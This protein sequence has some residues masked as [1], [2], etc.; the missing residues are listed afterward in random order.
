MPLCINDNKKSYNGDEPSPKGLGYCA[1]AEKIGIIRKGKDKEFWIVKKVKDGSKR[2]FNIGKNCKIK[3]IYYAGKYNIPYI[4][5]ICNNKV[6]IYKTSHKIDIDYSS[7]NWKEYSKII[8]DK[9]DVYVGELSF[10]EKYETEDLL[11]LKISKN[12]YVLVW[13]KITEFDTEDEIKEFY[14]EI[15]GSYSFPI[16][17]GTKFFYSLWDEKFFKIPIEQVLNLKSKNKLTKKEK[18]NSF[19]IIL[20][21]IEIKK[22]I[23]LKTLAKKILF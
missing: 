13:Y 18:A 4:V 20:D 19:N 11:F 10:I 22:N 16:A 7:M 6:Y 14:A 17:Y 21:G 1:H 9:Y 23:N 5:Y 12:K 15:Q 8:K 3:Y 2:W